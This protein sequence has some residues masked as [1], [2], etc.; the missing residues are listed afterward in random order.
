VLNLVNDG[1]V[2]EKLTRAFSRMHHDLKQNTAERAV[3]A[4][5]PFL[6]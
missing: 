3:D 2:K 5:L 6:S 1:P 4:I